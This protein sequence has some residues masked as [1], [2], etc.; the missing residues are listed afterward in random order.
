MGVRGK[1][2]DFRGRGW[3]VCD[4][5]ATLWRK[6]HSQV[7]VK[8]TYALRYATMSQVNAYVAVCVTAGIESTMLPYPSLHRSVTM[9]RRAPMIGADCC[10]RP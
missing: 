3:G 5:L 1:A 9:L 2:G 6:S 10:D 8:S 4:I 7:K